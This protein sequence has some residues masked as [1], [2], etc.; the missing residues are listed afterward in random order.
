MTD[1]QV[2]HGILFYTN[3][4]INCILC[5]VTALTG[6]WIFLLLILLTLGLTAYMMYMITHN[7]QHLKVVGEWVENT[8]SGTIT[9]VM[10]YFK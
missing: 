7:N 3:I 10:N 6:R 2:V 4:Y 1:T 5:A 8:F 9:T